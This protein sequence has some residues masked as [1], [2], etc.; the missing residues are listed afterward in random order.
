MRRIG[1]SRGILAKNKGIFL[2]NGEY[3]EKN[4]VKGRVERSYYVNREE[5]GIK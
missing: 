3:T 2:K 5:L 4:P 1:L